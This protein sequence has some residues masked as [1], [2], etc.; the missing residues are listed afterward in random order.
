MLQFYLILPFPFPSVGKTV[1]LFPTFPSRRC[2]PELH[3]LPSCPPC[4]WSHCP[5]PFLLCALVLCWT[6]RPCPDRDL[7]SVVRP[8]K[9]P[10]DTPSSSWFFPKWPQISPCPLFLLSP[11]G[12][13]RT[14]EVILWSVLASQGQL[15]AWNQAKGAPRSS[16]GDVCR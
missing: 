12:S 9:N 15:W 8:G 6:E 2:I 4:L 16:S 13:E 5:R 14:C 10:S 7:H 1:F 3:L 11:L